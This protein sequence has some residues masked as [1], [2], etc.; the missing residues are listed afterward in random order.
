MPRSAIAT[1]AARRA[2]D[3]LLIALIAFVFAMLA[4]SRILPLVT[5][6]TTFVVGGASMEPTIPL[7]SIV[8]AAP[9]RPE[10]LRVGDVVSLRTGPEH[11]IFTH[12]IVRLA[13]F[14]DGLFIETKGDGNPT[15][16]PSLVPAVDVLGR[17][18]FSAPYVGFGL[19]LL[20]T[21]QGI[22]F[23]VSLAS[24]LLAATWLLEAVEE[25][26]R[27]PI[28]RHAQTARSTRTGDLT[29]DRRSLA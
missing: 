26:Q 3:I 28:H 19:A 6:G 21:M 8:H 15:V 11:A 14:P 16:D 2:L 24:V 29:P 17:V 13:T 20:S 23:L 25:E 18:A 4:V 22:L 9:V 12:R 27:R 10:E 1:R 5:G 7:G